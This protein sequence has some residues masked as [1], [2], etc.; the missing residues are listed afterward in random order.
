MF[1]SHNQIL[2]SATEPRILNQKRKDAGHHIKSKKRPLLLIILLFISITCMSTNSTAQ[3]I[4][5]SL[6]D[7]NLTTDDPSQIVTGDFN[8]DGN[9]DLAFSDRVVSKV[10]VLLGNG[11]GSFG[12]EVGFATNGPA[13]SLVTGDF[14]KDGNL[15][16]AM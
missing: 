16:L 11:N 12:P 3:A 1:C 7:R 10:F 13:S 8:K 4:S 2:H 14:N 6:F 5:F 15:D 9:L